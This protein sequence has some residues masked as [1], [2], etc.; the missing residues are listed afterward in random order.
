MGLDRKYKDDIIRGIKQQTTPVGVKWFIKEYCD[1]VLE[2]EQLSENTVNSSLL[3][4][5]R[6]A[7]IEEDFAMIESVVYQEL[8]DKLEAIKRKQLYTNRIRLTN[9]KLKAD[10][11]KLIHKPFEKMLDASMAGEKVFG[12]HKCTLTTELLT[13]AVAYSLAARVGEVIDARTQTE[14]YMPYLY[15]SVG[16]KRVE[17]N[18]LEKQKEATA[19]QRDIMFSWAKTD[20]GL[21]KIRAAYL[22]EIEYGLANGKTRDYIYNLIGSR[23]N[24]A[25]NKLFPDLA[26][27]WET[28]FSDSKKGFTLHALRSINNA[29]HWESLPKD[30]T[31]E[32]APHTQI[33]LG[34]RFESTA[35]YYDKVVHEK[36]FELVIPEPKPDK[37]ALQ[38]QLDTVKVSILSA[39]IPQQMKRKF[40]TMVNDEVDKLY[41]KRRV[42]SSTQ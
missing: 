29:V 13:C 7:L 10:F 2:C 14:E 26:L 17:I 22:P 42:L 27:A 36:G 39:D 20:H 1:E 28:F 11:V 30:S 5:V 21:Q 25:L 16:D 37:V 6:R 35:I 38:A 18:H 9:N 23:I 31:A 24:R 15:K 40:E 41:R 32:R 3:P 19:H 12:P 8:R 34:H 33:H 4:Q